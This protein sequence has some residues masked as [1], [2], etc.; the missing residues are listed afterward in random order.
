MSVLDSAQPVAPSSA[1]DPGQGETARERIAGLFTPGGLAIF[2][3]V[4]FGLVWVFN[5]WFRVQH[6]QSSNNLEDW[7]H[8][9]VIPLISG[10]LVWRNREQL[11]KVSFAAFWPGLLPF[12][13]GIVCYVFFL[14]G[15][16]NH[17][18]SGASLLLTLFGASLMIGG[19]GA[20]RWLFLP[21]AFL[22]FGITISEK[23]MLQVT[24][25]LQLLAA[26]GSFILLSVIGAVSSLFGQGFTVDVE[27]NVLTVL[28]VGRPE[29]P[30]NV[31]E[32]CSGMRMV[33]AFL[34]LGGAVALLGCRYWW[35]RIL[36]MLLAAPIA[37]L[38]N[39]VRVAVLGLASL[40]NPN[41][42]AG[43]AHTV[44]GMILLFPSLGLFLGLVWSLQKI[45]DQPTKGAAT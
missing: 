36:L 38:M 17:M 3:G 43:D 11:A 28:P 5:R 23:I 12:L 33:I 24:F 25:P 32:A 34:A 10:F 6:F 45:V 9:Y 26:Q 2:I 18:F 13:L 31:A 22:A 44:I 1:D 14:V 19:P 35:Q 8:S 29:I 21:I 41:L 30:L 42:A 20:M 4:L 27:G 7:G 16:P 39:V 37:L 15:L 40:V